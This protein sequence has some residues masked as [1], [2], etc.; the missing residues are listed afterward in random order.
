M[1]TPRSFKAIN[2]YMLVLIIIS[3]NIGIIAQI[4]PKPVV[5][6]FTSVEFNYDNIEGIGYERGVT[7]RDPSDVI[8][9]GALYY[10]YYT[11]VSGRSPG[12]W[13]TIWYATSA[14]E[15]YTWEEQR[16]ILDVGPEGAFDSQAT[17]TPNILFTKGQYYLYYTGVKPTPGNAKGEFEN[18]STT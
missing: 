5:D 11:K 7:R 8:N 18:N 14:D 17:F 15:G 2:K 4:A 3:S 12:Y 10:V 6:Y 16:E 1:N 13:G 9:V